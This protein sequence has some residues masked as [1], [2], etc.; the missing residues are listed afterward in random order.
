MEQGLTTQQAEEKLKQFGKNEIVTQGKVSALGLFIE[1]LASLLNGIL[2]L[3][4]IF[5]FV[6]GDYLDGSFIFTVI[7]VNSIFSFLQEY[8]AEKAIEKLKNLITPIARVVRDGHEAQV[9]T[10]A[11]VPGDVVIL[12]EGD[13]ISADGILHGH[14]IEVDESILTGE[15]LPVAKK[16][17]DQ[18][19]NGTLVTKG[20]GYL[21]IQATGMKTRF[22]E[23][24]VS[25]ASIETDKTPL[26]KRL[27]TLAKIL[28]VVAVVIAL[29]IIPI[30][31][32]QN[33]ELFP[34]IL[35]AI[36][37]SVAAI[38][39]S[40]PAVITISLAI[41]TARMAKKNAIVR[42]MASVET[43]GAVQII[44]VDK[45]GTL[46]QNAMR[47]KKHW[48]T[49][50]ESLTPLLKACVF[51][52][53]ASLI[54]RGKKDT[55]DIAGDKTDGS[56]LLWAQEQVKDL[57]ILR[58]GGKVIDEFVFDPK[59]KTI[60]TVVVENNKKY[61]YV[62]GAPEEIIERSTLSEK[63]K[64]HII[65]L[66][67]EY[68]KEGLRVIAFGTKIE[69]HEGT[70]KKEEYENHLTFLGFVGIYDAPREEVKQA[71][72]KARTAGI[73]TIMVTGDNELTALAIAKEVGLIE[74]DD[75]DVIT[76]EELGKLS[77]DALKKTI[78]KT[79]VF[80]RSRPE[81]KLRL[82]E[83]LK[84]LGFVVG[85][86]GDGVNDALALKRA[87]VGIA[88]G[89]SGTDVAKEASDIVLTDD[90]FSTVVRAIEEGRIIYNNI[91]KA[92]TY[93]IS[94]N[95]SELSLIF[96]A[97]L[98]GMPSPL[99]PTQILWINLVTDGLPALALASDSKDPHLL[100]NKP[101]N[102][103]TPIL[104]K[105]RAIFIAVIG[106]TVTAILL[107]IFK[108]LLDIYSETFAR[109]IVFNLLIFLHMIIVF[110]VRGGSM[111]TTNRFVILTIVGTLILQVII[112]T[113]PFFQNIFHLGF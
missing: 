60:T 57:Q 14:D 93:L 104:T 50:G 18:L 78:L 26:Q 12:T 44:L 23:I 83:T 74:K 103:N 97:T 111:F 24:A 40:L 85:V 25:L 107:G 76:G 20:K 21:L 96:F 5:S 69:K 8:R 37:I 1:Q 106:F 77:D 22:G 64:N 47:V 59:T 101:R 58:D 3:A 32:L 35:L 105:K 31:I 48:L 33:R 65:L 71:I 9:L 4:G 86:T 15:S 17:T 7:F 36:S 73:Q 42:K 51:G 27:D 75:E 81:D 98:F 88:M 91:L 113:V 10:V 99:L 70:V 49:H 87:D 29:S 108:I 54:E 94:G 11:L 80:A 43:L 16:P 13:R 2:A 28:S 55:F 67:E 90:N 53:T 46:T 19:Y 62:R 102:P 34:I 30:G 39:Q 100:N 72:V 110:I 84:S 95:L 52:N 89:E 92:I 79:R 6:I 45:T 56:L 41:G 63:E 38:P 82:T 109:T 112:T 68:A 66:F 61:V